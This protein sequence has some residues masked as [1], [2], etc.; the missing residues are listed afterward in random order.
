MLDHGSGQS[1]VRGKGKLFS[2]RKLLALVKVTTLFIALILVCS[3]ASAASISGVITTDQQPETTGISGATVILSGDA[4]A[5]TTTDSNGMYSFI[6]LN[7]GNYTVTPTD[8]GYSFSPSSSSVTL[9]GANS[10]GNN[11]TGTIV[12]PPANSISGTISIGYQLETTG[13]SGVLVVLSGAGGGATFTDSRGMYYF[14]GLSNGSY[15]VIPGDGGYAFSPTS[16]S[17]TMSGPAV[18]QNFQ[19][20]NAVTTVHSISG[21][22]YSNGI[23]VAGVTVS[24]T[25]AAS[26]TTTTGANGMYGFLGL[27]DGN[28]TVTPSKTGLVFS[29]ASAGVT[30]SGADSMGNNFA[31]A[32][33]GGGTVASITVTPTTWDFGSVQPASTSSS[34]T[35][36]ITNPG[37]SYLSITS[38][39]NTG[40]DSGMFTI[41]PGTCSSLTPLISPGASCTITATFSPTSTGTKSTTMQIISNAPT[42][43]VSLTGTGAGSTAITVNPGTSASFGSI[44]VG[45]SSQTVTFGI[46][47][48]GGSNLVISS[49]AN[50]GGDAG[51]FTITTN[52]CPSLTP[53]I[54][55]GNSCT[56]N[57][58]FS[59]T[60]TGAKATTMQISSNTSLMN[61]SL[62]GTG[63]SSTPTPTPT[64]IIKGDLL[65]DGAADII[66]RNYSTGENVIWDNASLATPNYKILS[67]VADTAWNIVGVGNFGGG[68]ETDILWRNQTYGYNVVWHMSGVTPISQVLLPTVSDTNWIIAGTGNF[69][70]TG[71]TDIL[72]RNTVYGYNVVWH[73]N[74]I[75]P[76][77]ETFLSTVSDT[78]WVIAGTGD[79]KGDNTT[80]VLWR[81]TQSGNIA[82]WY[83]N[84]TTV[85]SFGAL[86]ALTVA[87]TNWEIVSIADYNG[88][89]KPDILWRNK[90]YGYNVLWLMNGTTIQS[91]KILQTVS[92]TDW[93]IVGTR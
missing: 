41:S 87:D 24:L 48:S 46:Y 52:T 55:P 11:F 58:V 62:T 39:A 7:A 88:D 37:G 17:L 25:G 45:S 2:N 54:T 6:G 49:I 84:G 56:I 4:S 20:S 27:S 9:S 78:N 66:W 33:G 8:G 76:Q 67:T 64:P 82:Y 92:N 19:A 16:G 71:N 59:P 29:P 53:T 47:N 43:S 12:P 57:V 10:T 80:T 75:T 21:V 63:I 50:S 72:W 40:G 74:G 77:A 1:D 18:T 14:T 89:G 70:G 5:T 13:L 60:S 36:T 85:T 91:T 65:T 44:V 22:I 69:N 31:A 26:G 61:I 42:T 90:V 3:F 35:F 30:L 68:A 79:F 81:N 73:M 86:P 15:T 28:Y 34:K 32:S 38:I 23:G 93:H 51:M 83:M